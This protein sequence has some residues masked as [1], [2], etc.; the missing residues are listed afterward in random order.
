MILILS[1]ARAFLRNRLGSF[2]SAVHLSWIIGHCSRRGSQAVFRAG[3]SCDQVR[4]RNRVR[5]TF[6]C[7]GPAVALVCA[8]FAR[9]SGR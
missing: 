1:K 7:C 2:D 3:Q 5:A 4:G 9:V 6:S 8:A